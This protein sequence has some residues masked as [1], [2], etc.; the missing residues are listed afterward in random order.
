MLVIMNTML[1]KFQ[2][3]GAF[4]RHF[5][6]VCS[7]LLFHHFGVTWLA[8]HARE[9]IACLIIMMVQELFGNHPETAGNRAVS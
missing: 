2:P 5:S 4:F 3:F 9:Y 7:S 6:T 8:S 1:T